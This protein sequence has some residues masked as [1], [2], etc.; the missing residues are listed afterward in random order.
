MLGK[1]LARRPLAGEGGDARRL[2]RCRFGGKLVLAGARL[3]LLEL[4][5]ELIEQAPAALGAGAVLHAPELGD[6]Q[7]QMRDQRLGR[8]LPGLSLGKARLR[9]L[10]PPD[11]VLRLPC[12]R[13][14]QRLERFDIVRK[15][16]NG[17][18]HEPQ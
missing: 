2:R 15:R 4:Q 12:R 5:L 18:F 7:L 11:R 10:G 14:D 9:F 3:Q 6:L 16:R 1:G 13:L 17:G 8:A